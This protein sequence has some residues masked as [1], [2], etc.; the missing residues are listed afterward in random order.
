M[1]PKHKSPAITRGDKR[2]SKK[3]FLIARYKLPPQSR[4]SMGAVNAGGIRK[5]IAKFD[6][7]LSFINRNK[8]PAKA[9]FKHQRTKNRFF[10]LKEFIIVLVFKPSVM[11]KVLTPRSMLVIIKKAKLFKGRPRAAF[12]KMPKRAAAMI[13]QEE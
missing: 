6:V 1:S 4:E 3:V 13:I 8:P 10:K 5:S 2:E 9:N 12:A 7:T 11:K